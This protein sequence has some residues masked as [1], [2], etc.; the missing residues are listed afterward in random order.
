[1]PVLG[2]PAENRYWLTGESPAKGL[3]CLLWE[4]RLR[5]LGC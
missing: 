5:W 3:E 4:E 2:S 1:M